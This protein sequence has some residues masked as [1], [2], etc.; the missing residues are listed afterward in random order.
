MQLGGSGQARRGSAG[1]TRQPLGPWMQLPDA[2]EAGAAPGSRGPALAGGPAGGERC[3]GKRGRL[4]RVTELQVA[5]IHEGGRSPSHLCD[6]QESSSPVPPQAPPRKSGRP[7]WA[8]GT[9]LQ[10]GQSSVEPAV[11]RR[12]LGREGR[13]LSPFKP[14]GGFKANAA[15]EGKGARRGAARVVR[16]LLPFAPGAL[17]LTDP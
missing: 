12:L 15:R 2:S 11:F 4:G 10:S 1:V 7:R 13:R 8:V 5:L 16:S 6:G 9:C 14:T 3:G 17:H